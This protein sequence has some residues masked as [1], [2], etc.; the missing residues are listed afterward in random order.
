MRK[1]VKFAVLAALGLSIGTASVAQRAGGKAPDA[2][3]AAVIVDANGK[4]VGPLVWVPNNP[5]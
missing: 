2:S 4:V 3:A 5:G 1:F